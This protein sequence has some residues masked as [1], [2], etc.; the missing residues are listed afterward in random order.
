M[1]IIL[2]KLRQERTRAEEKAGLQEQGDEKQDWQDEKQDMWNYGQDFEG[3]ESQVRTIIDVTKTLI[4][5][6]KECKQ[7]G[8]G[9]EKQASLERSRS[10]DDGA[11][12]FYS[13]KSV[14]EVGFSVYLHMSE[15][16]NL[17]LC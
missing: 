16:D 17:N 8:G 15:W 3:E 12:R 13:H 9:K 4:D 7:E 5:N 6:F 2:L 10:E 11:S 1:F 14:F